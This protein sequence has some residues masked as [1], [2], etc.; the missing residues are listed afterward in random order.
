MTDSHREL[1]ERYVYAGAITRNPDAIADL[2]TED[3]IFEA[4]LVSPGG[5]LPSRLAGREAI[6]A[7]IGAFQQDAPGPVDP[8]R[9]GYV[10][11]ETA[12]PGVFIAEIDAVSGGVEMSLVQIFR[13]RDG[14]IA[15]LRDYFRA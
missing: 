3:G 12:D 4:P 10:L 7:G 14:Q 11:H 13:I 2:F 9:S 5:P 8:A 1:F 15:H 6:R